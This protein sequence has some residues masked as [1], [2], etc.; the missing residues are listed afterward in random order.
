MTKFGSEDLQNQGRMKTPPSETAFSQLRASY[1]FCKIQP[2]VHWLSLPLC[3]LA[4][5]SLTLS[6]VRIVFLPFMQNLGISRQTFLLCNNASISSSMTAVLDFQY[7]SKAWGISFTH[8]Q[9]GGPK[10]DQSHWNFVS[11]YHTTRITRISVFAA[12]ILNFG[13]DGAVWMVGWYATE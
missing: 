6:I 12:A 13:H 10:N 7:F 3:C 2:K 1:L 8:F 11:M 5:A 9:L 4:H